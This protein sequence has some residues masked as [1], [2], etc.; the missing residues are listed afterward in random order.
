MLNK[1]RENGMSADKRSEVVS[2]KEIQQSLEDK[3][4][5]AENKSFKDVLYD[6]VTGIMALIA[7]AIAFALFLLLVKAAGP[8]AVVIGLGGGVVV[9]GIAATCIG[10]SMILDNTIKLFAKLLDTTVSLLSGKNLGVETGYSKLKI[11]A[12]EAYNQLKIF[13]SDVATRIFG[14]SED[15]KEHTAPRTTGNG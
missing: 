11:S 8:A 2:E 14:S 1:V 13:L 7:A 15:K 6:I 9:F 12:G 4:V 5:D 10:V 3:L